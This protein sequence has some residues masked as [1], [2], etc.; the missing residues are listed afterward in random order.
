MI[1]K[2]RLSNFEL[3]RIVAMFMVL[4]V[5]ADFF[6]LGEPTAE[7][8]VTSPK[9]VIPRL[10][11]WSLSIAC[12]DIFVLISGWFGIKPR[13]KGI[14]NFLFSVFFGLLGFMLLHVLLGFHIFL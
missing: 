9:D 6:S 11:F 14:C 1:E 3:L 2:E 5:H 7:E 12:V 10:L 13:A 8:C 4:L